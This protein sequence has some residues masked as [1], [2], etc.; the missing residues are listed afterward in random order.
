[1]FFTQKKSTN[2]AVAT[3]PARKLHSIH[4]LLRERAFVGEIVAGS[5]KYAFTFRPQAA[6]LNNR[7]LEITGSVTVKTPG[8][9]TSTVENVKA[10]LAAAQ[11]AM[12]SAMRPR[13]FQLITPSTYPDDPR[14]GKPLTEYTGPRSAAGVIY[15]HLSP[16][17]SR[18][19][20]VP[21]DLSK[22]QLNGQI[23]RAHV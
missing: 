18:A 22:V 17:D 12:G 16:L 20:G 13:A 15:F 11:G 6:A 4:T 23:G 10:T 19:L 21:Y 9:K 2:R 5:A 8:G 3:K 7:K 1:M 14:D